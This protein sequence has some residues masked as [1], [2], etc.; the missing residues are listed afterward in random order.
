MTPQIVSEQ[1][2][3]TPPQEYATLC[4]GCMTDKGPAE[5]CPNCGFDPEYERSRLVLPYWTLLNGKFLVG[6]VLGKPGGFGITYLAWDT[7]LHSATAIKEFL[8]SGAAT[9]VPGNTALHPHSR[10]D[11]AHLSEGLEEFL[12]EARILVRLSHPNIVRVREFF[13]ENDTAYLV[14]DYCD[15][16]SLDELL[17]R[18]GG[19]LSEVLALK[20]M[21]PL[22]AGLRE[23]HKERFLHRDIKPS[24]IYL[25]RQGRPILLDF[26]AARFA[27][28]EKSSTLSVVL[29]PGY[30]PLEQ[31]HPKGKQGPWTDV[32]ACGATL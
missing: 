29:T 4:L 3:P 23:V 31:Y 1:S 17:C 28:G 12:R 15:G 32:Y 16:V 21:L 5:T 26:G 13:N 6:K 20:L 19:R 2:L 10:E 7:V 27:L 18:K 9:R 11:A 30:A 24:N 22:L 14:M 25:T 8:P